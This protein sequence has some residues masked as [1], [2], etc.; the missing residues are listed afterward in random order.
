MNKEQ[1]ILKTIFGSHLYGTDTPESDKDYKVIYM[2][3]K[4]DIL[5]NKNL[6]TSQQKQT[7]IGKGKNTKEDIDI[8]YIPLH[9]FIKL[10]CQ[11]D[12]MAL[13]LLHTPGSVIIKKNYIWAEIQER[14][15]T[16][17]TRN[18]KA[19][20]GY[21]RKQASKYGIKGSRL[22]TCKKVMNILKSVPGETRVRQV[23]G[24][25]FEWEHTRK[26]I[27]KNG[28][29]ELEV[30]NKKIQETQSCEYAH[31]IIR[32]YYEEYGKRAKEAADNKNI[33]WK[34]VSHAIRA[35]Y[36]VLSIY[37]IRNIIFPL[38]QAEFLKEVKLGKLDYLTKVAPKLELLMDEIK[39]RST[40]VDLPEEVNK[41]YWE[42]WLI[43]TVENYY[44]GEEYNPGISIGG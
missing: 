19:F 35:A 21:A 44:W 25:I 29:R 43:D 1:I 22:D 24:N 23:L 33:D 27:N 15:K 4:W 16:F 20:V 18:L 7:K 12:T 8:E 6:H 38:E 28:I 5:L 10:A 42:L 3:S 37:K 31:S 13:D 39:T 26:L 2:P 17:Y 14:R 40:V 32:R 41:E 36:E 34:A 9:Q 30:C 11:G